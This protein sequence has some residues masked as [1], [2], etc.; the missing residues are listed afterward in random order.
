LL[1]QALLGLAGK[2]QGGRNMKKNL[3]LHFAVLS[4][5]VLL[6][7]ELTYSEQTLQSE[8]PNP[9]EAVS[10]PTWSKASEQLQEWLDEVTKREISHR[11][12]ARTRRY[13]N[14]V[15]GVLSAM[16]NGAAGVSFFTAW[17]KQPNLSPLARRWIIGITFGAAIC[18]ALITALHL[19]ER[20]ERHLKLANECHALRIEISYLLRFPPQQSQLEQKLSP[21][22]DRVA[23]LH[24]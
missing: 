16:L 14:W 13:P 6:T 23:A 20:S 15:L 11:E 4:I 1:P 21:I 10:P 2:E 18:S 5:L 17:Q 7:T 12:S 8:V 24:R 22:K 9:S 19:G 3:I